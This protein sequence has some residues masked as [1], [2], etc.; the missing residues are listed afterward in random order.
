MASWF[1][2][3]HVYPNGFLAAYVATKSLVD[4]LFDGW[5]RMLLRYDS[6][7][8]SGLR[9]CQAEY[10][11]KGNCKAKEIVYD[12]YPQALRAFLIETGYLNESGR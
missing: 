9:E 11:E 5:D 4:E 10:D 1:S 7:D 8:L 12:S 3:A 2:N 6:K